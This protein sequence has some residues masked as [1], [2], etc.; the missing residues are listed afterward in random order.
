MKRA[1]PWGAL[2]GLTAARIALGRVGASLPTEAVL[3]FD[4]AHA[5]AR[6]AVHTPLDLT[7]LAAAWRA[8]QGEAAMIVH[9]RAGDR[10]SYLQRPD[11]G[12]RLDEASATRLAALATA[13][14][15]LAIVVADGLSATGVAAHVL[16]LLDELL[17]RLRGLSRAPL[18]LAGQGRVALGDEIGALLKARLVLVLL[19]E[20]PGLSSPD[21]LGAYLTFAPRPGRLDAERNCVS[22]IRPA[23][24][25]LPQAAARLAW[26]IDAAL[27]RRLTG[28]GL[29]DES[30]A[31]QIGGKSPA[32]PG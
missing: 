15:D 5:L 32:L 3:R 26:L 2:A 11:L 24:L 6:D 7:A 16:D 20:R 17:P 19:G 30:D 1:D 13:E 10:H 23:G 9:S 27:T 18:V 8:R 31:P 29:K 12:R 14:T 4:V 21:S 25:P 22:N 28:V